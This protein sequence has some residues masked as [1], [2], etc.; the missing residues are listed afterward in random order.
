MNV[1]LANQA[2]TGSFCPAG[3]HQGLLSPQ[4]V[5]PLIGIQVPAS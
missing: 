4:H 1:D 2:D 3:I 5:N